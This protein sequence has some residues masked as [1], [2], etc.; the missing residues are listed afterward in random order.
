MSDLP[1]PDFAHNMRIDA[2]G[3]IYATDYNGGLV[4]LEYGG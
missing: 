4:I 1:K 3:L 2:A